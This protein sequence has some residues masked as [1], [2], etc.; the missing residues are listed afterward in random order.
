MRH[1]SRARA[2]TS[3]S[4]SSLTNQDEHWREAERRGFGMGA[5]FAGAQAA[6]P[7]CRLSQAHRKLSSGHRPWL[8]VRRWVHRTYPVLLERRRG[9]TTTL[10][11]IDRS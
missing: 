1:Q 9:A 3:S 5:K 6:R 10:S 2:F 11:L 4:A 8:A 7:G